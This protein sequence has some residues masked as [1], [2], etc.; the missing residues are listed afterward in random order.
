MGETKEHLSHVSFDDGLVA[1]PYI[2]PIRMHFQRKG[3]TLHWDLGIEQDNVAI[4][5]Y[6]R[7]KKALLFVRQFRPPVFVRKVRIMPENQGKPWN[8]IEWDKYPVELGKTLELCA[9]LMDKIG[10]SPKQIAIEEIEEE[11]GYAVQED[12]IHLIK[13]YITGISTSGSRQYLFYAIIDESMKATEGGGNVYEGEFIEKVFLDLKQ[14]QEL[15]DS[16]HLESPPGLLYAVKWF[17]DNF[18]KLFE[19]PI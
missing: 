18:T 8:E 2:K 15:I 1:S 17:F 9:G 4:V 16:E 11:C 12:R 5:L 10:K 13:S 19:N 6:H 3:Q 7:E 14:A